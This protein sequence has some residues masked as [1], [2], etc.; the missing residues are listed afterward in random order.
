MES[1]CDLKKS[2]DRFDRLIAGNPE[3]LPSYLQKGTILLDLLQPKDAIACFDFI[4][5]KKNGSELELAY[6][7]KG[8]ALLD[9]NDLTQALWYF[10]KVLELN[11]KC[12]QAYYF[13]GKSHLLQNQLSEAEESFQRGL[14]LDSNNLLLCCGKGELLLKNEKFPEALKSFEQAQIQFA[15][16]PKVAKRIFFKSLIDAYSTLNR[17][18]LDKENL[19]IFLRLLDHTSFHPQKVP[20]L[21]YQGNVCMKLWKLEKSS[22]QLAYS[23]AKKDQN[24][25][26]KAKICYEEV[27]KEDPK[28]YWVLNNK[29]L[30]YQE[31]YN[32][33]IA[34]ESFSQAISLRPSDPLFRFNRGKCYY[35]LAKKN[36]DLFLE[37]KAIQDF[38]KIK[39]E[40][41]IQNLSNGNLKMIIS[42]LNKIIEAGIL[43]RRISSHSSNPYGEQDEKRLD[44]VNAILDDHNESLDESFKK[45]LSM[46]LDLQ[47][48]HQELSKKLDTKLN[49]YS[50]IFLDTIEKL[51]LSLEEQRKLEKY[52]QAFEKTFSVTLIS[53][54]AVNSGTF[55]LD[56]GS[57]VA[58]AISFVA[59]FIP[60]FGDSI[61]S[62]FSSLHSFFSEKK[63]NQAV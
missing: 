59:T 24:Y 41:S 13:K 60:I 44:I 8:I 40:V 43:A 4:I 3:F 63:L 57:N 21:N 37:T 51:N 16:C 34:I 12:D 55:S 31:S 33:E 27:L 38:D 19:K 62:T 52:R 20:I 15:K 28:N 30:V 11:N 53:C 6:L 23:M 29:G 56:T 47:N 26:E 2:L 18:S 54:K 22:D 25:L 45:L 14:A 39:D 17:T 32:Y 49:D 35:L 42:K 1:S 48:K 50:M 7:Y 61:S 5:D 10:K 9:L 46:I 58:D 36:Q